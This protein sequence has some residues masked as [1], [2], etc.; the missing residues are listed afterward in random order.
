MPGARIGA[1]AR[2][3]RDGPHFRCRQRRPMD[4]PRVARPEVPRRRE[5]DRPQHDAVRE[6]EGPRRPGALGRR[7]AR[8]PRGHTGRVRDLPVEGPVSDLGHLRGRAVHGAPLR[9]TRRAGQDPG[10]RP[11]GVGARRP[12]GRPHP[13]GPP[14]EEHRVGVAQR[15]GHDP[16]AALQGPRAQRQLRRAGDRARDAPT[17]WPPVPPR[18]R[19]HAARRAHLPELRRPV[20]QVRRGMAP[21]PPPDVLLSE[22]GLWA[23]GIIAVVLLFEAVP[24]IGALIPAQLFMLGAGFLTGAQEPGHRVLHLYILVPVA[25][26][27]LYAAD[28]VSFYLGRKYGMHVFDRLPT[29]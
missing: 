23:Y 24:V 11:H 25:F 28:I 19:A 14:R 16:A 7:A 4:A 13:R 17:L 9:R 20:P 21:V 6:A 3:W 15:R 27:S 8:R 12:D 5:R 10:V 26:A 18:G 29:G 1:R 22:T 2:W